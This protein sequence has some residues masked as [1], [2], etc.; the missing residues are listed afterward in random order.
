MPTLEAKDFEFKTKPLK[1]QLEAL[2]Q[3]ATKQNF[4]YL[5]EMGCVD[6][7]TEFLSNRGWVK[8]KDFQLSDW[9]EPLLVGQATP[10]FQTPNVTMSFLSYPRHVTSR[11]GQK[12]PTTSLVLWRAAGSHALISRCHPSTI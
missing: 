7:E 8:F 2:C 9:E 6:G 3:S 4:A 10:S 11:S 12:K 5:M 1:H